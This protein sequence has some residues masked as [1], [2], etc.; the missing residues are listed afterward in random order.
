MSISKSYATTALLTPEERSH[1][2][3]LPELGGGNL[4]ATAMAVHPDPHIP[5]IRTGRPLINTAGEE[6]REFTL[7][8]LDALVQSW[9]VWYHEQGVGPRDRVALYMEDTFAYTIHLNALAQLGAIGVLIN[10]K[11]KPALALG[12]CGRTTPVGI[13]TTRSRLATI[14]EGIASLDGLRW[15]QL[16]EELPAPPPAAL[17]EAWRFKH[18]AEDPVSIMHSSGTTGIPKAVTQTH[19]S[20]VAG[21]RFRLVNYTEPAHERMMTAQPQSHLGCIVYTA[22]SILAGTP[23]VALYDP[24]G[25]ELAAA[26]RQHQPKG[27]MAFAHAYA[28]LAALETPDGTVD[29]VD[30]WV[31]MGDAIHEA[32]IGAILA[33][34]SPDQKPATFYDRFGTT[35]LG[36]GLVVQPRT[37]SSERSDRRVGKPDPV[38][39][40]AVLRADGSKAPVGEVGFF[41][42]KGPSITAGYWND[43]DTTYRSK[44]GGY[45]LTGDLVYQDDDGNYFVVDRTKDAFETAEGTGYSVLMEEMLLSEISAISDCAVVAGRVGDRVVPVAVVITDESPAEAARLLAEANAVLEKAG[46]PRIAVLDIALTPD[47]FPVGVTGKVLKRELRDRYSDLAL[48]SPP[49][50]RAV[51]A[52]MTDQPDSAVA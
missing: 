51:A 13:Y 45:W 24:T 36:W 33:K 21:P 9:S 40:V 2:A 20:S 23:L 11:A 35:E 52:F 8:Q 37:L 31:N 1:L 10:S 32:H 19:A 41:G 38:A 27:V 22:Y 26:V 6:Q 30:Y 46:C 15:V 3:A 39:E 28:E 48:H 50:N 4:L 17:P 7:A 49:L 29:S 47:D 18:A 34:R 12:L 16:A 14:N 43:S 5:F 44:L 25:E 42:A